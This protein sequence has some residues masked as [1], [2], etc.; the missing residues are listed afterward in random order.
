LKKAFAV[1][2]TFVIALLA[3]T[4]RKPSNPIPNRAPE[5]HLFLVIGDSLG[6][7]DTTA[8]PDTSASQLVLH[9]Y[10][11]DPDGEVIGFQWAWDDTTVT[12][13]DIDST[14]WRN[15]SSFTEQIDTPD[16]ITVDTTSIGGWTFT[17]DVMDTFYV[18]IRSAF[19]Y[20]T[21][22]VRAMD[23][24]STVDE[25]PAEITFPIVNS[26]PEIQLPV[27]LINN[28]SAEHSITLGYQ[29]ITWSGSD[30][31]GSETI[32][33]YELAIADSS[34]HW[35]SDT[36][37]SDTIRFADLD[38]DVRLDSLTYSYTFSGLTP[39]CYRIFLRAFDI[40]GAYSDVV[41][42][43]ETTGV[44]QVIEATGDIL[45]VGDNSGIPRSDTSFTKALDSLGLEYT[46]LNFVEKPFYYTR[47]FESSLEDFKILVYNAG[48]TRHF[49]ETGSAISNFINAGGHL[50]VNA[51]YSSTDTNYYSF[52]PYD[53]IYDSDVFRPYEFGQVDTLNPID[54]YPL[55]LTVPVAMVGNMSYSYGFRP[56][57]PSGLEGSGF[58]TL[59]TITQ[60]YTD[61]GSVGDTI[62]VRFPYDPDA[63]VQEPAKVVFFSIPIF[64]CSEDNGFNQLIAHVLINEFADE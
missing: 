55:Y 52:M 49:R 16:S 25:T 39:G 57:V 13:I 18:K 46:A 43:P 5:T 20:F 53:S 45:F 47:D 59:Y 37:I 31:D 29:T 42:Y 50:F 17:S 36:T 48:S 40:A 64:F 27:G 15:D 26:A 33:G 12:G 10:G 21:F 61:P 56:A 34:F 62:G 8:R 60:T 6:V 1:F 35:D 9:W 44:W 54:G 7:A 23:N 19:D 63:E 14:W 32:S 28:Y 38:W 4:E 51:T 41:Y 3:C 58:K 30:P 2:L 24:D 22:Y 11:D